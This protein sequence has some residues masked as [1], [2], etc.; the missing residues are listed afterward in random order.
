MKRKVTLYQVTGMC[1]IEV[2][3]EN[4]EEFLEKMEEIKANIDDY[5]M[6]KP[7]RN[8]IVTWMSKKGESDCEYDKRA[9][10]VRE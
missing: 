8:A 5:P 6:E 2:E 7:D 10:D 3:A 1:D 9:E 4:L